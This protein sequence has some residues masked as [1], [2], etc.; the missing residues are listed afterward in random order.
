[1]EFHYFLDSLVEKVDS[2]AVQK[3]KQTS[4]V[5]RVQVLERAGAILDILAE[6][7][8]GL[9]LAEIAKVA[10]VHKSTAHRILMSLEAQRLIYRDPAGGRY[11]LGLRLFELGSAAIAQFNIR[12]RAR[13]Y[14]EAVVNESEETVHLCV[15]DAGEVLYLDKV[16]PSRSIR[17]SS[18]IGLRNPAHCT[19]VG[20]AMMAWMPETEVESIVHR[21]GLQKFTPKTITTLAEL[22]AELAKVREYGYA[23]DDE[24]HEDGVR[25][26]A[27]VVRDHSGRPA[28]AISISAPSFRIPLGKIP[29]YAKSI[30]KACQE[31]SQEW[32]FEG[33]GERKL[34][35]VR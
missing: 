12:D 35:A 29:I 25:C 28:A 6:A 4:S 31:L 9:G 2:L 16:E 1:M 18:R 13:R 27:S 33:I 26:V 15:M 5:Y 30:C 14:L 34:V 7:Q 10:K 32:G 22:R 24:E 23:I 8:D 21:H 17:M 3:T 19:A 20:K 11:R